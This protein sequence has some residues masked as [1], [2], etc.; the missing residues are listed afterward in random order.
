MNPLT[1]ASLHQGQSRY[2][3]HHICQ[4]WRWTL[5]PHY[6][7]LALG[8]RG[9]WLVVVEDT[10]PLPQGGS[11]NSSSLNGHAFAFLHK[12]ASAGT[13]ICGFTKHHIHLHFTQYCLGPRNLFYSK[14]HRTMGSRSWYLLILTTTTSLEWTGLAECG[15]PVEWS[16]EGSLDVS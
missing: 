6:G 7:I 13:I 2:C 14:M 3:Y 11:T 4:L 15:G 12:N 8:R 5:G 1:W 10:W 16:P 9:S